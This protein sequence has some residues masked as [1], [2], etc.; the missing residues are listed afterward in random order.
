MK[1]GVSFLPLLAVT[2]LL[3]TLTA[4][5]ALAQD[6]PKAP[7]K[8]Q[9]TA[10]DDTAAAEATVDY[11]HALPAKTDAGAAFRHSD[12]ASLASRA[13]GRPSNDFSHGEG[14]EQDRLRFPGDLTFFGGPTVP[15]AQSHPIFLASPDGTTC[16]VNTCW[17]D[18][19][20]FLNDFG[21]SGLSHVTDQYVGQVADNRY[22]LGDEFVLPFTPGATPLTDGNIRAI[23]H[24][25]AVLSG[26]AGFNHEFHVFLPPGQD[27]CFTAAFTSC[28]SPDN[29]G[30]FAFCA[31]HSSVNFQDVGRVLYSVEPFQNVPGCN[32][33]PGTVNGQLIDSTNSTLSHELIETITDPRGNAWFNFTDNGL[34][35]EEIGDEC[36]LIT[37]IQVGNQ[38]AVFGDPIE[39]RVGR[40][41]FATQPEYS[42]EDHACAIRP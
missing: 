26:E 10:A 36:Q 9:L 1:K 41:H 6:T 29:P 5:S 24:A 2:V 32:V 8:I 38:L 35:G 31:Y 22:T 23:V 21:R 19:N 37:I 20:T 14:E 18:P 27:E 28:Y 40:H 3:G 39:F 12:G 4:G 16:P 17:G 11:G 30:S 33:R 7:R 42:N 13:A 25:A 15:F 34:A